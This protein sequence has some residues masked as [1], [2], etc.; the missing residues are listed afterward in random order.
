MTQHPSFRLFAALRTHP[1]VRLNDEMYLN[2]FYEAPEVLAHEPNLNGS[3][4][5]PETV[6]ALLTTQGITNSQATRLALRARTHASV[7]DAAPIFSMNR[8]TSRPTAS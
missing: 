8:S 4:A 6:S 2:S 3:T 7:L 5:N 1:S